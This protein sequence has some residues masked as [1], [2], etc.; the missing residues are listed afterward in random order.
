[1]TR[2]AWVVSVVLCLT[3]PG[4]AVL[5]STSIDFSS[6]AFDPH[7]GERLPLA[8]RLVDEGGKAASLGQFFAGK[9]VVLVLDYLRCKS[10][11][12]LT[13]QNIVAALDAVPLDAGRDF[14]LLAISI[15][16]RDG[17]ADLA[18][19]KAHYVAFYHHRGANAGIHFLGSDR[20]SAR[21][22]ADAVGFHYRYDAATDQYIHPAGFVIASP[23]GRVSGYIF[24]VG[25]SSAELRQAL[26]AAAAGGTL[27]P[28][29]RLF[30]LCHI[31]GM[32]LGRYTV[33]V[34]AA[35]MLGNIAAGLAGFVAFAVVRRRRWD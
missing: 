30:L 7:P 10:L 27:S 18:R 35:L 2:A 20:A 6:L 34:M 31:E 4:E 29:E 32:P 13:L 24:G 12:G 33:P 16:P 5:A 21:Q 23:E 25:A 28:L 11:C 9:P 26:A 15:D 14:E 22:I 19:A 17:A 8:T 1:M 3:L